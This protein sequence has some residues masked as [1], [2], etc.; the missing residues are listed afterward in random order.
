MALTLNGLALGMIWGFVFGFVE[1][2]R[3]SDLLGAGLCVSF[4]VASGFVKTVG[5]LVMEWGVSEYWMPFATGAIFLGPLGGF[6]W[7]LAKVPPPD[8]EDEAA[9][10]ERVPMDK[11]ARRRFVAAYAPGLVMLVTA[12]VVLSAYRDFRDNFAREIWDALGYADQPSV[13]TTAELPVALGS[14][15][16]VALVVTVRDS[17]R[18]LFVIHMLMLVGSAVLVG[19]STVIYASGALDPAV[20]MIAVG[21][22]LYL[23]Y[24]PFNCVLFDRMIAALGTVATAGFLIYLADAAGYAGS[25][26]VLLYKNFGQP[27]LSWLEFF[28]GFSYVTAGVTSLLYLTAAVYFWRRSDRPPSR[29][30]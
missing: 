7:L 1:G 29:E 3:V 25:V 10:V 17:R 20:W 21:L 13:L 4:I 22:G 16:A 28:T 2:R 18:A 27:T 12:Y 14:L 23:G 5:L 8:K 9:R 26:A 6:V 24:V 30:A 11:K 15:L 19:L